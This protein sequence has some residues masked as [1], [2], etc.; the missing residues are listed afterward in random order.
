M[1][2]TANGRVR[3]GPRNPVDLGPFARI[4]REVAELELF[5]HAFDRVP[6]APQFDLNDKSGPSDLTDDAIGR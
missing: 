4:A 6:L 5:L 1:L 3:D 2:K